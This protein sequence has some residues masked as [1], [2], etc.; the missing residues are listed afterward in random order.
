MQYSGQY[1]I[2]TFGDGLEFYDNGYTVYDSE[3]DAVQ[4]S[5]LVRLGSAQAPQDL[6]IHGFAAADV[7]IGLQGANPADGA[8]IRIVLGT[9]VDFAAFGG[10]TATGTVTSGANAK[11]NVTVT[12]GV[13]SGDYTATLS[14]DLT[15]Y[16]PTDKAAVAMQITDTFRMSL[17]GTGYTSVALTQNA[18]AGGTVI[19]MT[20]GNGAVSAP[21]WQDG[22]TFDLARFAAE[23]LNQEQWSIGFVASG[24]GQSLL[25]IGTS[26][27]TVDATAD[28]ANGCGFA[29]LT[30]DQ[31]KVSRF[32][33][34]DQSAPGWGPGPQ[35]N[36]TGPSGLFH[37]S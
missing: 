37:T 35:D 9:G 22:G 1:H 36:V 5:V 7:A 31:T 13:M 30:D 2:G 23:V 21:G 11:G 29:R 27:L 8:A 33:V 20:A 19:A 34:S 16:L 3:Q 15:A 18:A 26:V 14:I 4:Q 10:S 32:T 24:P 25:A 12:D 28:L 17:A 6:A